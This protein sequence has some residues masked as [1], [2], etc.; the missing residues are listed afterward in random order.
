MM[1]SYLFF[2]A[3][4]PMLAAS[5]MVFIKPARPRQIIAIAVL[6]AAFICSILV[7]IKM[8]APVSL[9]IFSEYS[10]ILGPNRLSGFILFF[11][12]FFGLLTAVY[13]SS[14]TQVKDNRFYFTYLVTLIVFSNLAAL[15][16]DFISLIFSWGALLALLYAL[17]SLG[18][19][20][21]ASKALSIVGF[22]D[23]SLLLGVALY[24]L[25]S[26]SA[27]MPEGLGLALD[28]P[29]KWASFIL[30]LSGAFAKAGCMPLHTWIPDAAEEAPVP[31]MAIF[32]A[33]LDKLLGIYLLA[34]ISTGFFV[35][36]N[37]ALA[38]LLLAGSLTIIIAGM[39]ALIQH[40]LRKLLAYYAISQA[41]YMVIGFGAGSAIGIAAGLFH[42]LNN[43][44]YNSGLF[45]S[46]GA[47]AQRKN[48]FDLNKLG[49]LA[50][51]MPLEFVCV[52]VFSLS[53]SGIPPFNG[54]V[55]KWMLYQSMISGLFDVKSLLLRGVF[56]FALVAAM[57]GSMLTLASFIKV[58]YSVFLG[59]DSSVN[60]QIG[61]ENPWRIKLPLVVLSGL[62]VVFGLF[63][64]LFIKLVY[65]PWM[66]R[67]ISLISG[68]PGV[69]AVMVLFLAL[70][71]GVVNWHLSG[72]GRLVLR[73]DAA[74]IGGEA[75]D[76]RTG[77]PGTEFYRTIEDGP[78]LKKIYRLMS[79]SGTDFYNLIEGF[80]RF[81]A[82][83]IKGITL[84]L[85]LPF[86]M[87][88]RVLT[89]VLRKYGK[90]KYFLPKV[91]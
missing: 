60:K 3:F 67:T 8:P 75:P 18:Q 6:L 19:G 72:R 28:N 64:N 20:Q 33:S 61:P 74:F 2:L 29:V 71:L 48:T 34:R 41:G 30:M 89:K 56:L 44:V 83:I 57:F 11:I 27:M 38:L 80:L 78:V 66:N 5:A 40:D 53:I 49:G 82:Y 12:N 4:L 13:S 47:V 85:G 1:K 45:L 90:L 9:K 22:G 16:V 77:F 17:L 84:G 24:V 50:I 58:L 65:E 55:S 88:A 31:V 32:P 36:N 26:G 10:A 7:F 23:F 76:F 69:V 62:C 37:Y 86:E 91:S 68:W 46:G 21:S 14:Y 52:L 81:V 63:P 42:M 43:A 54:F 79:L 25:S 39:M 15:S 87:F 70:F 51:F 35:L 73:R 59:Q